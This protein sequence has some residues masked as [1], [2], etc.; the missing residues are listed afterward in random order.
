MKET[1]KRNAFLIFSFFKKIKWGFYSANKT[2]L[3]FLFYIV[4]TCLAL[5]DFLNTPAI[6]IRSEVFSKIYLSFSKPVSEFSKKY[7]IASL[8]P[9]L[10]TFFLRTAHLEQNS[11]WDNFYY[12]DFEVPMQKEPDETDALKKNE[13]AIARLTADISELETKLTSL[14]NILNELRKTGVK[15]EKNEK[16]QEENK[17]NVPLTESLE[18]VNLEKENNIKE[19]LPERGEESAL[20]KKDESAEGNAPPVVP[21]EGKK[22]HYAYTKE[23]PLRILM[24]GD[25]QM[26][27]IAGGFMRLTGENSSVSVTEI[28]VPSSGFVRSDYYNWLKK[29]TAVFAE[30]KNTPFDIAVIFLGMNDY[31][32]FYGTDGK[33]LIRETPQWEQAYTDKIKKH[34][35]ILFANTKKVYWLGMPIVRNKVYNEDLSYIEKIQIKIASHYSEENLIRFSLSN[36]APGAGVPYTDTVKTPTGTK[37]KLMRDDGTHYTISGGEYI[38]QSF[39]NLLYAHWNLEPAEK[40]E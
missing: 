15:T 23:N 5:G 16:L 40:I 35:D 21:E 2:L 8:V 12:T 26:R 38:M 18:A 39:L 37:I 30:N 6:K 34:L 29:L 17:K 1:E 28:S 10:R 27:S 14:K 22:T 3:F 20:N 13:A 19:K 36:T 4:C 24:I 7:G 32:N 11:A 33:I 9:A 25:S 31:Q